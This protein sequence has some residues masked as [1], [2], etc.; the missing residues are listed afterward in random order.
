MVANWPHNLSAGYKIYQERGKPN[1]F[2]SPIRHSIQIGPAFI[3]VYL[4]YT[5]KTI[6]INILF[7]SIILN[8]LFFQSNLMQRYHRHNHGSTKQFHQIRHGDER[9]WWEQRHFA[10]LGHD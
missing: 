4:R 10:A 3:F 9:S 1:D 7:S 6:L 8:S 5:W 2:L